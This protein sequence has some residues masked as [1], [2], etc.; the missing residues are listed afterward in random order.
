MLR[1][2]LL[3]PLL[4]A[5]CVFGVAGEEACDATSGDTCKN[6]GKGG[7]DYGVHL[8]VRAQADLEEDGL[9]DEADQTMGACDAKGD[10]NC[11]FTASGAAFALKNQAVPVGTKAGMCA[12]G[13]KEVYEK[14]WAGFV[15]AGYV[16]L[17]TDDACT[18][19]NSEALKPQPGSKSGKCGDYTCSGTF[20]A[21]KAPAQDAPCTNEAECEVNC[22]DVDINAKEGEK[23]EILTFAT[24]MVLRNATEISSDLDVEVGR[25]EIEKGHDFGE[26]IKLLKDSVTGLA[27]VMAQIP[28][29]KAA[30]PSGDISKIKSCVHVATCLI[31][32]GVDPKTVNQDQL[33]TY[34]L[35]MELYDKFQDITWNRISLDLKEELPG[36]GTGNF[37]FVDP[38]ELAC[39]GLDGLRELTGKKKSGL[40]EADE[41]EQDIT[42]RVSLALVDAARTTHAVLDAHSD[43][44]SVDETVAA[45]HRAWQVPCEMLECDHTNYWDLLGASHRHSLALIESGASAQHMRVHVAVRSRLEHRFQAFLGTSGYSF[46]DRIIRT[47]GTKTEVHAK[48]YADA[49]VEAARRQWTEH[50]KKY[51]VSPLLL[52]LVSREK[53]QEKAKTDFDKEALQAI[54][55]DNLIIAS[56]KATLF[57]IMEERGIAVSDQTEDDD[58]ED[59]EDE[60]VDSSLVERS[61]N[62]DDHLDRSLTRKGFVKAVSAVGKGI[63]K[64]G[65]AIGNGIVTAVT[66][67]GTAIVT[68]A[69]AIGK[70]VKAF[71]DFVLSFLDCFGFGTVGSIGYNKAFGT[72][73]KIGISASVSDAIGGIFRGPVSRSI[74]IAI[75]LGIVVGT[76][77]DAPSLNVGV[78][79]SAGIACGVNSKTGGSCVFSIGV[80][81]TASAAVPKEQNPFCPF[82]SS[83]FGVY[84]CSQSY[85]VTM[86]IMCCNINL[87]TGCQSCGKGGC[88]DST[89]GQASAS[90]Q[91]TTANAVSSGGS[92]GMNCNENLSGNGAG[93][94]GCQSQ[95]SSGRT[96]Q[97]WSSQNPHTHS[98]CRQTQKTLGGG[99]ARGSLIKAIHG[100]CLDASQRNRH[101]G[102]VHMWNC[103]QNNYNQQWEY[104][105]S[106][107]GRIKNKHGICLDASQR[108][109]RGGKVHMWGCNAN[110]YNQQWTYSGEQIKA[111]HGKCLDASQRNRVGGKVHMWDCSLNNNNQKWE[112]QG[113]T[114]MVWCEN[115]HDENKGL[116]DHNLCRNPSGHN[117]IWCYTT[118]ANKRWENCYANSIP[119][120]S[121]G[122]GCVVALKGGRGGRWCADEHNNVK[123]N[124]NGIGG[125]EKFTVVDAGGGKRALKGGKDKRY[126]ADEHNRI[127]CNRNG[128]GGWEKFT[129][130]DVSGKVSLRGGK[131]Q[132]YCADEINVIKCNRGHVLGWEKFSVH[133]M[134]CGGMALMTHGNTVALKGGKDGRWCA[135][136]HN[137]WRCNRNGIGGWEKF[138]V[139]N[140]GGGRTALRGGKDHR[141]CA[142]EHNQIKCNRGHIYGWEKFTIADAGDGKVSIK[143]GKDHRWCADEHNNVKCNRGH[144]YG[145][146]KFTVE[147]VR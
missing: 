100:K 128:I 87:V 138:Y 140:A 70:V 147:L 133:N 5:S 37:D 25:P 46:A 38:K 86:K 77:Y 142:D 9:E 94:R 61:Q 114:G 33:K 4:C 124:R 72:Y 36:A 84:K 54:L 49:L 58:A 101:G 144:V 40:F 130:G 28:E 43:N 27:K 13:V 103:N 117:T 143:G 30:C 127:K 145:W 110:N 99:A 108:N 97:R 139:H 31:E 98:Q 74:G 7:E 20:V 22:C 32:K 71:V 21:K 106:Q 62:L 55:D 24:I 121:M 2:V 96:C 19:W 15:Q 68:V 134:G 34:T 39:D 35:L 73:F 18:N 92:S 146:E 76:V 107:Q 60:E 136:E 6:P 83:I 95:S 51:G 89:T 8:Q 111:T 26:D 16:E 50:P 80:G 125:W 23:T 137:R 112:I 59:A 52:G 102:L 82:G 118:D 141:W 109:R 129:V 66:A 12:A 131:D 57:H 116:G 119:P 44:S 11:C 53:L 48:A 67:V 135:D 29:G 132:R 123:C 122:I 56:K 93:Y 41:E 81:I 65:K 85:G 90:A 45:L 10:A 69:T 14:E 17:C 91:S 104:I 113:N 79:I 1:S 78:G 64:V 88:K 126:C 63:A 105:A 3:L 42:Y 120:A 47:E 115:T 75:N